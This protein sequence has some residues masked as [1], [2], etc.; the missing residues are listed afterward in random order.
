[1][2]VNFNQP[3]STTTN[4][5]N[6]KRLIKADK[7]ISNISDDEE[8]DENDLNM[9]CIQNLSIISS[10]K[11]NLHLNTALATQAHN[12][13]T[14]HAT[15]SSSSMCASQ[16]ATRKVI[17][18]DESIMKSPLEE[19]HGEDIIEDWRA[20]VTEDVFQNDLV[21][22]HCNAQPPSNKQKIP[23]RYTMNIS[24][25]TK[26]LQSSFSFFG[27][28]SNNAK[29]EAPK[30]KPPLHFSKSVEQPVGMDHDSAHDFANNKLS[31]SDECLELSLNELSHIRSV[32][33][34]AELDLLHFDRGLYQDVS[35]GKVCFSCRKN[36]FNLFNWGHKCQICQQRV[37]KK[38]LRNAIMVDGS[39]TH[40]PVSKLCP[41][42][43]NQSAHRNSAQSDTASSR[44]SCRASSASSSSTS[45]LN[46]NIS[47]MS[48]D[49]VD[50]SNQEHH[51]C[52]SQC[53]ISHIMSYSSTS[54]SHHESRADVKTHEI[55]VC[56]DCYDMLYGVHVNDVILNTNDKNMEHSM[57]HQHHHHVHPHLYNNEVLTMSPVISNSPKPRADPDSSMRNR[58]RSELNSTRSHASDVATT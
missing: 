29:K 24:D 45:S 35:K 34:K 25:L 17:K 5:A 54:F 55:S 9:L 2:D 31:K 52:K 7:C 8:I 39:M 18:P 50:D 6:K 27:S 33:T 41:N 38:C 58:T 15:S 46:D 26:N 28:N 42:N 51:H 14:M 12:R 49:L 32:L 20:L 44:S 53:K 40:V 19:W 4:I 57:Q 37:C 23:R 30:K 56:V 16:Q 43:L 1:M 11:T 10:S 22:R 3:P 21:R 13:N 36:S 47:E 48:L